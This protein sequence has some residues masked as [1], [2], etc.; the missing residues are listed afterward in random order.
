MQALQPMQRRLSKSTM[1]SMRR[2]S[3][4]V[5]QIATHGAVSQWLQ[6]RTPKCRLVSG[7]RALL[8]VFHPGAKH[9]YW[10]LV[11][12]LAGYGAGMTTDAAILVDDKAVAH[13]I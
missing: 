5:G 9:A 10:N 4:P 1:P 8:D 6:R 13:E 3:V 11:L 12:L 7:N 2:Y